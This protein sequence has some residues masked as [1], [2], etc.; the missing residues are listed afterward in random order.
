MLVKQQSRLQTQILCRVLAWVPQSG[1]VACPWGKTRYAAPPP[2]NSP[3]FPC[4]AEIAKLPENVSSFQSQISCQRCNHKSKPLQHQPGLN[5]QD[6]YK[7]ED[8][9][10]ISHHVPEH[11]HNSGVTWPATSPLST[12]SGSMLLLTSGASACRTTPFS[13]FCSSIPALSFQISYIHLVK[14]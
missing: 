13:S 6:P 10:T 14:C 7:R 12:G 1:K 11:S 4:F 3:A 8:G 9:Q 5:S 2:R